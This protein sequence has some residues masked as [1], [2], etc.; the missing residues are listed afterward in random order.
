VAYVTLSVIPIQNDVSTNEFLPV[1][2]KCVDE[3]PISNTLQFLG[4]FSKLRKETIH[5]GMSLRPCME[6][7]GSHWTGFDET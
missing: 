1:P 2:V 5:F 6:Q 3:L 4:V 7:L